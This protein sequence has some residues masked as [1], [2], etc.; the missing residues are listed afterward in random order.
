MNF[1]IF[2]YILSSH[3]NVTNGRAGVGSTV[4]STNIS[5]GITTKLFTASFCM[6]VLTFLLCS[7]P[8]WYSG[9][10]LNQKGR[11]GNALALIL[12][13]L[14]SETEF[15]LCVENNFYLVCFSWPIRSLQL[16]EMDALLTGRKCW[17]HHFRPSLQP[18]PSIPPAPS[19]LSK[20]IRS[21]RSE[22]LSL[23]WCA[24]HQSWSCDSIVGIG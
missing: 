19:I 18:S 20:P 9:Q 3:S 10:G 22:I 1:S 12:W 23:L 15:I 13:L 24:H 6:V 21:K 14:S 7:A 11:D 5:Y 2:V 4:N 17:H 8:Q 16:S